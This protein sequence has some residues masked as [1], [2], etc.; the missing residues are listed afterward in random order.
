[1][2]TLVINISRVTQQVGVITAAGKKTSV[3]IMKKGRAELAAGTT[4][5]P[6]WQA[7]NPNA[8]R[9]VDTGTIPT[10]PVAEAKTNSSKKPSASTTASTSSTSAQTVISTTAEGSK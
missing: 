8:V 4:I 5:D 6:R 3:R 10:K 7:L 1:M 2:A 9:T